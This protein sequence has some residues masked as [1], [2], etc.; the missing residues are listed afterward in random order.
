M[1]IFV[2]IV[3]YCGFVLCFGFSV[4]WIWYRNFVFMLVGRIYI[5]I[6][7]FGFWFCCRGCFVVLVWWRYVLRVRGCFVFILFNRCIF[8][9][10]WWGN[11]VVINNL[12]FVYVVCLFRGLFLGFG[13]VVGLG[14]VVRFGRDVF[15]KNKWVFC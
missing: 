8:F 12:F 7:V 6:M 4:R 3:R 10:W 15:L 9:R 1:F 2:Y 5:V 14:C 13:Y 11:I